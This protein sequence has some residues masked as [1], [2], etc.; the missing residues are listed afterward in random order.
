MHTYT[1]T[2][3]ERQTLRQTEDTERTVSAGKYL[4]FKFQVRWVQVTSDYHS[5]SVVADD[6]TVQRR[7][8]RYTSSQGGAGVGRRRVAMVTAAAMATAADPSPGD[9][10]RLAERMHSEA[11]RRRR[12][13]RGLDRRAPSCGG[14][15]QVGPGSVPGYAVR[16]SNCSSSSS[17]SVSEY[18]LPRLEGDRL[19]REGE[20]PNSR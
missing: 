5:T 14:G 3:S 17:S 13:R 6:V 7:N 18:A 11:E 8:R 10:S 4:F 20:R 9:A 16:G 19:R 1:L 15:R 12:R 2:H